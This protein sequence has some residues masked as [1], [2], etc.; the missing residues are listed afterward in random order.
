MKVTGYRLREAIKRWQLRRDTAAGQFEDSIHAFPDEVKPAPRELMRTVAYADN[1]IVQLQVAQQRYNLAV[2]VGVEGVGETLTLAEAI[3][4]VG[5]V[6]RL[7]KAWRKQSLPHK[8]RHLYRSEPSTLR[9]S[10]KVAAK[11]TISPEDAAKQATIHGATRVAYIEAIGTG[12]ACEV[13]IKD[14]S[15]ALFE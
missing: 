14:L 3:K 11:R 15:P 1:A 4:A 5:G 12:N 9:D 7:E 13:D 8:E 6:T 10:T 2:C